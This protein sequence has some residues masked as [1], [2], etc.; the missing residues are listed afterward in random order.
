MALLSTGCAYQCTK[1]GCE[2]I[3]R[4]LVLSESRIMLYIYTQSQCCT[5]NHAGERNVAAL[6][7]NCTS[8][9]TLVA[10]RVIEASNFESCVCECK[11][12]FFSCRGLQVVSILSAFVGAFASGWCD[13]PR[14]MQT[15]FF[16]SP[17]WVRRSNANEYRET[18]FYSIVPLCCT[19]KAR[20]ND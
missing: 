14:R 12:A 9:S 19:D 16:Q 4:V 2:N 7:F 10:V 11:V 1:P 3:A 17:N 18:S 5:L 13:P 20:V 6:A 15:A 8:G